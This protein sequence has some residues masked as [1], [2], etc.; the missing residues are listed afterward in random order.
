ME[1]KKNKKPPFP[2]VDI[3]NL[4][5]VDIGG[6]RSRTSFNIA[7]PICDKTGRRK[8]LNVNLRKGSWRCPK[9]G[10]F[11]NAV[12]YYALVK[13]GDYRLNKDDYVEMIHKLEKELGQKKEWTQDRETGYNLPEIPVAS[14]DVLDKTYSALL[15]FPGFELRSEHLANLRK[16][17][18]DD[19]SI[20]SNMYRS[21]PPIKELRSFIPD[22]LR[23]VYQEKG[24][25]QLRKNDP[26]NPELKNSDETSFLFG[27]A[28]ANWLRRNGCTLYGVP[29]F[30]RFQKHWCFKVPLGSGILIPTRNL[31]GQIVSL[32][33][34]RDAGNIRYLTISSKGF[35][36]GVES[37]ISRAHWRIGS[38]F[39][40][41]DSSSMLLLTEGPL[42]ADVALN[43]AERSRLL[44]TDKLAFVAIQ[45]VMNTKSLCSDLLM[46]Q[47]SGCKVIY[48]A[49]DMDRHTN[50]NVISAVA[51][52]QPKLQE[53]G[54]KVID[55]NW[56]Q[57]Y[58]ERLVA[59]AEE[60]LR[61]KGEIVGKTEAPF[62][63]LKRLSLKLYEEGLVQEKI[64]W[65]DNTK[66]IDDFLLHVM[67]TSANKC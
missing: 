47:K 42:K 14:D 53:C 64:G 48:N 55:L 63:S 37:G 1:P 61:S 17:G 27:L 26:Y 50:P 6:A 44:G 62:N 7:C 18:L 45:G 67:K 46:F 16:R 52:L 43:L 21:L 13:K 29:G 2:M 34:R 22:S 3:L 8:H 32:Q 33:L 20:L 30:F 57:P 12:N 38:K 23:K 28:I 51:S 19:N 56:D 39:N 36:G 65:R 4:L 10:S 15:S 24:W 35:A 40:G 59:R 5:H 25:N 54:Y 11:G 49:L 66:G 31:F 58:A 41:Q 60:L 9:C